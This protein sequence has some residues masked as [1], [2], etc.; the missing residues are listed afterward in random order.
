MVT[1]QVSL[2]GAALLAVLSSMG[3]AAAATTAAP[4]PAGVTDY[5]L[6][7]P[8]SSLKFRFNQAGADNQGRLRKFDVVLRFG[9]AR[10]A[11]SKLEVTVDVSSLDTGDE[12]R[13][14]TLRSADLF[15]VAKF[16]QA[17]FK[18][19]RIARVSAGRYEALGKL[20]LRGVTRDVRIPFSFRT[21]DEK[22]VA[23]AYMTG[24]VSINRLDFGIG[25]GEW[26]ATDQVANEVE[27]T[28]GLRLT[29]AAASK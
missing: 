7:A 14:K 22:G 16:P 24:H 21:A 3:L 4:A 25:Q 28:F 13:D 17:H 26:K 6:D 19:S 9:D 2:L 12:E 29:A 8:R 15:S 20:T 18:A 23:T 11:A 27:V 1:R 5:T 10:L